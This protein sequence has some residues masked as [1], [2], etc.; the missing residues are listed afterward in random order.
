MPR[1]RNGGWFARE[2]GTTIRL[3]KKNTAVP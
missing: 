2:S 3:M 1:Q